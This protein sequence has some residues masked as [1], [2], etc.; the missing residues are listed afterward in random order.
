[1]K[2]LNTYFPIDIRNPVN[3]NHPLTRGMV[4]WLIC[5]PGLI[6]G[7]TW[8]D[9]HDNTIPGTLT[10]MDNGNSGWRGSTRLFGS[11][12]FDGTVG[13]VD[14]GDVLNPLLGQSYTVMAWV[15]TSTITGQ[16]TIIAYRST[17]AVNPILFQLDR[18]GADVRFIV[19][20]TAGVTATATVSSAL[21]V[22]KWY[23]CV[24]VRFGNSVRAAVI[25]SDFLSFAPPATGAFGSI[26]ENSL[27]IG[28]ITS[29]S[30][31]RT[32]FWSG[33]IDDIKIWNRALSIL[34]LQSIYR[35]S[36]TNYSSMLNRAI[37]TNRGILTRYFDC[38]VGNPQLPFVVKALGP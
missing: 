21:T 1:M 22:N 11:M 3:K 10:S 18:N 30:S 20:D 31:T 26:A 25:S 7:K 14:C 24:G 16:G 6:G 38:L 4:V 29:G 8:Y 13:Y 15:N 23:F 32:I 12:L 5:L 37:F 27:N 33:Y 34:E 35:E 9:I 28:A 36:L 17:T 19:R 2:E